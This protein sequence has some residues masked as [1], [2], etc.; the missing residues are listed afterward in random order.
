MFSEVCSRLQPVLQRAD[1]ELRSRFQGNAESVTASEVCEL[2]ATAGA[3]RKRYR[4]ILGD[5]N[6]SCSEACDLVADA[7]QLLRNELGLKRSE[8]DGLRGVLDEV[9]DELDRVENEYTREGELRES[10]RDDVVRMKHDTEKARGDIMR[11]RADM[12]QKTFFQ[13]TVDTETK[14]RLRADLQNLETDRERIAI[15]LR[16]L[17]KERDQLK[18]KLNHLEAE[19]DALQLA[20]DERKQKLSEA[21]MTKDMYKSHQEALSLHWEILGGD[22]TSIF[23]VLSPTKISHS[24]NSWLYG[25]MLPVNIMDLHVNMIEENKMKNS[26]VEQHVEQHMSETSKPSPGG[27]RLVLGAD[28]DES[29]NFLRKLPTIFQLGGENVQEHILKNIRELRLST[30]SNSSDVSTLTDDEYSK[31][32]SDSQ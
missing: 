31:T 17:R 7:M 1:A 25:Q 30:N 22:P 6:A 11:L 9:K 24:F 12:K 19:R 4:Q 32:E 18:S 10:C 28:T 16:H 21:K 2:K 5:E 27:G 15:K 20:G 14:H 3:L 29:S 23:D 8:R 26:I 13:E